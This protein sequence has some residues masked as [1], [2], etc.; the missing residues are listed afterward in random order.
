MKLIRNS[1]IYLSILALV[2]SCSDN[3]PTIDFREI[4]FPEVTFSEDSILDSLVFEHNEYLNR[5]DSFSDYTCQTNKTVYSFGEDI[6]LT[7]ENISQDTI[8]L[9]PNRDESARK[10][11]IFS[12][13]DKSEYENQLVSRAPAIIGSFTYND[14]RLIYL[15]FDCV[16]YFTCSELDLDH[17]QQPILP[18]SKTNFRVV[19]PKRGG[20]YGFVIGRYY[21]DSCTIGSWGINKLIESNI[22]Q[23]L[24]KE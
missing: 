12:F 14:P 4:E 6:I 2:L 20:Y 10:H 17:F 15:Q 24:E 9:F 5:I 3:K 1:F 7:I 11:A 8:Y 19:M 13:Y 21:N 23:I 22:F 18:G 16:N